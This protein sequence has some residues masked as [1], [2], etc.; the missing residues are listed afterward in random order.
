MTLHEIKPMHGESLYDRDGNLVGK[1][2]GDYGMFADC[3]VERVVTCRIICRE[4]DNGDVTEM[5]SCCGDT[6]TRD[7]FTGRPFARCPN[8]GAKVVDE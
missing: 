7:A 5:H 1:W 4:D 2:N 6:H 8:C 3:F